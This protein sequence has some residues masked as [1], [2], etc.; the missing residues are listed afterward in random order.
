DPQTMRLLSAAEK[1]DLGRLPGLSGLYVR[2]LRRLLRRPTLVLLGAVAIAI[3]VYTAYGTF[4]RG[5]EFFPEVEPEVASLQVHAR[6]DMS[7]LERDRLVRA[8]EQRIVDVDGI[9]T[10]YARSGVALEGDNIDEDVIGT[11]LLEL[12]DWRERRPAKEIL[13]EVRK[14]TAELA[15]IRLEVRKE[16][17]GPPVGKP[18]QVQ[19]SAR[20]PERL[21]PMVVRLRDYFDQLDG[22]TDVTDTRPIP[23][24]EWRLE[25]DRQQAGR[26][27][28]DIALVGSFVQLVT[29]GIHIGDYR[30]DDAN[31]EVEIRARFPEADRSLG[32]FDRLRVNTPYGSVPITN[33]VTRRAAPKVGT[34][35]RVDGE[36]QLTVAAD[37]EEGILVDD[38]AQEIRAWLAQ[39]EID[40]AITVTFK[41]EDEEQ[42]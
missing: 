32:Q 31:D 18:I 42:K 30:P 40:P 1:G 5:V 38:K 4:G 25:I 27:G 29:N 39:Q 10:T 26:F 7:A 12:D 37:V 19:L 35:A 24:I 15:G 28:A 34:L 36:R 20:F 17:A 41:G 11:I 3:G 14:R 33:F 8:M 6:G 16:E 22:L 23:G 21:E 13:A 2:L 9:A